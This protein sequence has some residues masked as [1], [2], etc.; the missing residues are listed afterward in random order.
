[1]SK[2]D[3]RVAKSGDP[4]WSGSWRSLSQ[5][6]ATHGTSPP[7]ANEEQ[8][9]AERQRVLGPLAA[10]ERLPPVACDQYIR[11]VA[12]IEQATAELRRIEPSLEPRPPGS[13]VETEMSSG[14][15]VWVLVGLIWV[16]AASVVFCT[17]A[18]VVLLLT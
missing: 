16:F 10:F 11:E 17:I 14:R 13:E 5:L 4:E 1:M 7:L 18:A 15:S 2:I 6:A 9:E 12:D 3:T 8:G